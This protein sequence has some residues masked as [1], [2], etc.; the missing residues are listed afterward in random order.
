MRCE[1]TCGFTCDLPEIDIPSICVSLTLSRSM[2]RV[3]LRDLAVAG[4]RTRAVAVVRT[5]AVAGVRTRQ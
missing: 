1:V 3:G 5:R 2:K 4:I